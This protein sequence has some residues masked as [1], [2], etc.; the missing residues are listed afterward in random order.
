VL[1]DV[2][3]TQIKFTT[4]HE[5]PQPTSRRSRAPSVLSRRSAPTRASLLVFA[6]QYGA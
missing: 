1:A 6:E 3:A 4:A 2:L 5:G